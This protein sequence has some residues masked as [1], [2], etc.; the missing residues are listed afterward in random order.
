M[1]PNE[2]VESTKMWLKE[3]LHLVTIEEVGKYIVI[4]PRHFLQQDDWVRINET[5]KDHGIEYVSLGKGSHWRKLKNLVPVGKAGR[6]YQ[7]TEKSK[8]YFEA[9][10]KIRTILGELE[11]QLEEAD[12]E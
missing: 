11:E 2:D 6:S 5:C 12:E 9:I 1:A 10:E 4:R 8:L 7:L 3:E